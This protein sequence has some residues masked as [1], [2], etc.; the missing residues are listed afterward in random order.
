MNEFDYINELLIIYKP[1]LTDRQSI[2]LVDY[3]QY[4]LS[5]A[6]ISEELGISR[7]AVSDAIEHAKEKLLYYENKLHLNDKFK[8][9]YNILNDNSLTSEEKVKRLKEL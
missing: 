8:N 3:F 5:L 2:I 7:S 4:N 9:T 1:L 6:E